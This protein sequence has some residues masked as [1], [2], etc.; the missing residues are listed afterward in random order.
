MTRRIGILGGTFDPI[1]CGHLDLARAAEE[2][3]AL[4]RMFVITANVPPHRPQPF[5]SSFHRFAMVS[6]AVAARPGWRASDLE[7]RLPAPSY[8]SGTLQRF[9]EYG[10]TAADLFFVLGADA[11][12]EIES[13]RDY[14]DLLRLAHFAVVSRPGVS[15]DTLGERLPAL[16]SRMVRP[17]IDPGP[18]RE[19]M[20]VLI[21]A[22]TADVSATA[23]RRR[24]AA[25]ES[26]ATLVPPAVQHH[27]EQHGLYT[28]TPPERR[29]G[30]PDD[31]P[32]AERLH[33]ED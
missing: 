32:A 9:H 4:R 29:S 16:R 22:C 14:P 27:I 19:P 33:G 17:P 5:A 7:L 26:I 2:T 30:D 3:L 8:T 25:R 28:P 6:M 24:I 20:I 12:A 15:V 13:W 23:I 10:Y 21:D 18:Y 11:F 1:H 31:E